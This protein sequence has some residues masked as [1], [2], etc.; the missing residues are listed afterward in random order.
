MAKK[1]R[2]I[3]T[4]FRVPSFTLRGVQIGPKRVHTMGTSGAIY[5]PKKFRDKVY[6]VI[7]LP[8][9]EVQD[10]GERQEVEEE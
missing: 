2:V 9:E 5:V 1:S 6:Y 8:I 4:D 10:N 7:L 3:Y